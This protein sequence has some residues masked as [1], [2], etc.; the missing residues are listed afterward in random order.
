MVDRPHAQ[1]F[2]LLSALS[3]EILPFPTHEKRETDGESF[4][5]VPE[6]LLG[7]VDG[8]AYVIA[9]EEG[10]VFQCRRKEEGVP[11]AENEARREQGLP[12]WVLS[13]C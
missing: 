12:G 10:K 5:R 11:E 2:P 8:K 4:T 13:G 6:E 3:D 9:S 7:N 1:L